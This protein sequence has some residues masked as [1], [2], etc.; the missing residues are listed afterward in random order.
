MRRWIAALLTAAVAICAVGCAR[1]SQA[2]EGVTL[3][4]YYAAA[5]ED[6]PG[7]DILATA[8][9]PWAEQAMLSPQKQAE[10]ALKQLMGECRVPGFSSPLP[11]GTQ[12]LSCTV[13]GSTAV[14]D[15]SAAYGQLSGMKLTIA[16][17]C[18]T[19]T[20]TQIEP[21]R[22]VRILVNGQELAYRSSST[23][24]AGDALLSS[25]EDVV[26]SFAA[27]LYFR[28]ADG[29]LTGEDR[30][31]TLYEG[32][33]RGAVVLNALLSSPEN[34]ELET[35]LPPE[36][37]VL[38]FRTEDGLC[39]MNL[40]GSDEGLLPEDPAGQAQMLNSIVRSLCSLDGVNAVQVLVDGEMRG[41]LGAVDISQPLTDGQ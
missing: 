31:L 22:L 33:S 20:L 24:L 21:I 29:E 13:S 37:A 28:N 39:L 10:A 5:P 38:S 41:N 30:L 36:F 8:A 16:D 23:L 3:A 4:V 40:P 19:L 9:V 35:V 17:Y 34:S 11:S 32:E 15:F 18:V 25:T 26:R 1:A 6:V 12:L 14:V 27:T 7:G 2:P